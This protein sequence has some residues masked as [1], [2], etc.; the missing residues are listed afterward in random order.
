MEVVPLR[1][2]ATRASKDDSARYASDR[3]GRHIRVAAPRAAG[4]TGKGV[5]IAIVD[6]GLDF[7]H[8]EFLTAAGTTRVKWLIDYGLPIS[9]RH[10][11]LE[12]AFGVVDGS[13]PCVVQKDPVCFGAIFNEAEINALLGEASKGTRSPAL[14]DPYGHGTHVTGIAA[15]SGVSGVYSGVAPEAD[16]IV[17]RPRSP[18]TN[19]GAPQTPRVLR[20][21]E[22]AFDRGAAAGSPVVVNLSLSFPLGALDEN[23]AAGQR[24]A[25]LGRKPGQIIVASAGNDGFVGDGLRQTL[26]LSPGVRLRVPIE[27]TPTASQAG[28]VYIA[29]SANTDDRFSLG[30]DTDD[31]R[32]L[33]PTSE[34]AHE[35]ETEGTAASLVWDPEKR[36]ANRSLLWLHGN[37]SRPRKLYMTLEGTGSVSLALVSNPSQLVHFSSGARESSITTPGALPHVISVGCTVN[38]TTYTMQNGRVAAAPPEQALDVAGGATTSALSP[39]VDGAVCSFSGAG[40]GWDG[41]LKPE[42]LAPGFGVISARSQAAAIDSEASIFSNRSCA[43]QG[44]PK[45]CAIVSTNYGV[46]SGTSMSTPVVSG[47]VALLLQRD[48]TLNEARARAAVMAGVHLWRGP[49]PHREQS[50]TGELDVELALQAV[51]RMKTFKEVLPIADKS[52]AVVSADYLRASGDRPLEVLLLLRGKNGELADLTRPEE[53]VAEVTVNETTVG[54]PPKVL[55]RGPGLYGYT[56]TAPSGAGPGNVVLGARFRGTEIVAPQTVPIATDWWSGRYPTG[57]ASA[58]SIHSTKLADPATPFAS[59]LGVLALSGALRRKRA[60]ARA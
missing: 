53:L 50:A 10:L 26:H 54:N 29:A 25:K 15:G 30:L 28:S 21:I 1:A 59:G 31:G 52:W 51:D 55:R 39:L 7:A 6:S 56:F 16:L 24:F 12:K 2:Q 3:I 20:G 17:V 9:G 14:E 27:V 43:S 4:M 38:R 11:D 49:H 60:K 41:T 32:V 57:A 18:D 40:P 48:P 5:S 23:D 42:V 46:S 13:D 8:E 45:E 37:F 44:L 22:F 36:G 58:C 47:A 19:G 33:T 34:G 35:A